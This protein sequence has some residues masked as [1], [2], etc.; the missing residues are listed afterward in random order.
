MPF[1]RKQ[2]LMGLK[3]QPSLE[4]NYSHNLSQKPRINLGLG[5]DVEGTGGEFDD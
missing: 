5:T 2:D 4:I 3:N 1:K